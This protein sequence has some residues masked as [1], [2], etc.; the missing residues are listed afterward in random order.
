MIKNLYLKLLTILLIL[1]GAATV[2]H[3]SFGTSCTLVP[4]VVNAT[5]TLNTNTTALGYLKNYIQAPTAPSTVCT[6]NNSA[7]ITF[8]LKTTYDNSTPTLPITLANGYSSTI[9]QTFAGSDIATDSVM[10]NINLVV[11]GY[12]DN[13]LCLFMQTTFGNT[14]VFCKA[15]S[16][17]QTPEDLASQQCSVAA[18]SCT[19]S[20]AVYSMSPFNFTGKAYQCLTETLNKVFYLNTAAC[21]STDGVNLSLLNPF[22]NFQN[23]LRNAVGAALILY[24]MFFGIRILLGQVEMKHSSFVG[25]V[26]KMILVLYFAVGLGPISYTQG[27][28]N[29]Q[30]GMVTWGL[31]FLSGMIGDFSSIVFN[32][33]GAKGLCNFDPS[34]YPNGY[35]YY[36]IW[37]AIDCRLGY[38][39]GTKMLSGLSNEVSKYPKVATYNPDGAT[40]ISFN[41]KTSKGPPVLSNGSKFAGFIMMQGF[42][43][44]GNI[45]AFIATLI[46]FFVFISIILS[47]FSSILVCVLTLYVMLYI[48]PIFVPMALFNRTKGYF[49]SW[50]KMTISVALQPA[51][52]V[53]FLT[54]MTSIYDTAIY[55]NC[56]FVQETYAVP[57]LD[58][59][60]TYNMNI[61]RVATPVASPDSCTSSPG[62]QM[63]RYFMGDGWGE[64]QLL[65][66]SLH[67]LQDTGNLLVQM[68]LLVTISFIFYFFAQSV[69]DF[70]GELSGG[71][72]MKS[73]SLGVDALL[74]GALAVGKAI[75][76]AAETYATKGQ[77]IKQKVQEK[78]AKKAN[79]LG[80]KRGGGGG[81]MSGGL[82]GGL[83]K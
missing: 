23:S 14:P 75:K 68:L 16:Y 33:S 60:S 27:N 58:G 1:W 32:A 29:Q 56:S 8:N 19:S 81:G 80:I 21:T 48:A 37:D 12:N 47:F 35:D 73:V 69:Q 31:P 15:V 54:L 24:V 67:N 36:A 83:G 66:M 63:M 5:D 41:D 13:T 82:G 4:T 18:T 46:F 39:L 61:Y 26:M 30:N 49:D 51:I 9:A 40:V 71:P 76:F 57:S 62:V 38:Y 65:I 44:A 59:S 50:L 34:K 64:T 6:D 77:N 25:F 28:E 53:G 22:V 43:F 10:Q 3:A 72:S 2:A 7:S 11:Q 45:I 52:L 55:N 74:K 79:E 70:A 17:V 42:L 20:A 78:M